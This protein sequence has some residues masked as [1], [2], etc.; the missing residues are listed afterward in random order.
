MLTDKKPICKRYIFWCVKMLIGELEFL[1][2]PSIVSTLVSCSQVAQL[3]ML[4][5]F[6]RLLAMNREFLLLYELLDYLVKL[7]IPK[8]QRNW[9][10]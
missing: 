2:I 5:T 6:F 4:I 10:G 7:I 8:Y 3:N 1:I 9:F